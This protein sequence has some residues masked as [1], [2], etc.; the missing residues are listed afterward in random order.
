MSKIGFWKNIF[1][2]KEKVVVD[3]GDKTELLTHTQSFRFSELAGKRD[4]P[5]KAA[6]RNSLDDK[7]Y[8]LD[9]AA[10]HLMIPEDEVL[11]KGAAGDLR[12]YVDVA[13]QSG[14]WCLHDK[15]GNVS[16]ATVSTIQSGLLKLQTGACGD[17][18]KNGRA[19]V[20]ALD[21]CTVNGHS[22]AGVD[23]DTLANL[24]A[25]GPGDKR[26]FPLHPL[27]IEPGMIV[28]LSPLE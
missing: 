16:Q 12:L 24:R 13:G 10:L 17:L 11:A 20:R 2:H 1:G 22:G 26:F 28:L 14:H 15:G 18:A 8:R 6:Y 7:R 19:I 9:A 3:V 23:D 25:W 5:P 4:M 27:T 21:F